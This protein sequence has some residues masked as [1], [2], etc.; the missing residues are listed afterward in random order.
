M[1]GGEEMAEQGRLAALER[2]HEK[3]PPHLFEVAIGLL[4]E[5]VLERQA[6]REPSVD[7]VRVHMLAEHN[8][9]SATQG[10]ALTALRISSAI[11]N[12][13]FAAHQ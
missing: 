2:L 8:L 1:A 9:T 3:R 5:R 6:P 4:A 10:S 11:R 12:E 7:L 13:K